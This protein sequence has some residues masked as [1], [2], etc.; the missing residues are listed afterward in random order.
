MTTTF[1]PAAATEFDEDDTPIIRELRR[2][3]R[4]RLAED[5]TNTNSVAFDDA[6]NEARVHVVAHEVVDG[7][8]RRALSSTNI[9]RLLDPATAERELVSDVLGF[10]PLQRFM[11]DP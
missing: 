4:E 3:V 5:D 8:Q 11:D 10:G 2:Q 6:Q 9:P 1:R 7:Y